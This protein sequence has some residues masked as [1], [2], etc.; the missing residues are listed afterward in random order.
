[1]TNSIASSKSFT[2]C[3]LA[4][5]SAQYRRNE[6]EAVGQKIEGQFGNAGSRKSIASA[7][8]PTPPGSSTVKMTQNCQRVGFSHLKN[9]SFGE[10]S[11]PEIG[12]E[13]GRGASNAEGRLDQAATP[14]AGGT[15]GDGT[16]VRGCFS[17]GLGAGGLRTVRAGSTGLRFFSDRF[18]S[19]G[20]FIIPIPHNPHT[21]GR[22][23]RLE[24][25]HYL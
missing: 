23:Q 12:V 20:S 1:M 5:N 21:K 6:A 17:L 3:L 2:V 9:F 19:F 22:Q 25:C 16:S 10:S 7:N 13:S 24:V 14:E 11:S 18:G 4:A 15:E 8:P